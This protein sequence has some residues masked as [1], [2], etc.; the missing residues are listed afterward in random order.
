MYLHPE[1]PGYEAQMRARD[2]MLARNPRLTFV[3]AHVASLEWSVDRL[4]RFLDRHPN[5]HVD[6]AARMPQ[7]Q[8]QSVRAPA[9][10]GA[11]FVR[12]QDRLLY[13]SDLTHNP[14]A[15]PEDMKRLAHRRWL[16]DW[17]YLATPEP[18]RVEEIGSIVRGLAL[19]RQVVDKIYRT[20]AE[21][22]LL[23]RR[24]RKK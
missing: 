16:S 8:Y 7:I 9:K 15:D 12:Y 17:R 23:S 18:Q 19:P 1:I 3:G 11:F 4:A 13:G 20:N 21:R 22:V 10:V 24:S 6:L 2:R 5:A 14:G